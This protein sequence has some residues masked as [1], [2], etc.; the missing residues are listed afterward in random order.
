[1]AVA[2]LVALVAPG[3]SLDGDRGLF[4]DVHNATDQPIT[5]TFE[6]PAN[7]LVRGPIAPGSGLSERDLFRELGPRCTGPVAVRWPNGAVVARADELCPG[8][9][10][11]VTAQAP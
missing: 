8:V 9:V 3:C 7:E 4:V 10:W 2:L 11:R 1:M 5:V 6:G